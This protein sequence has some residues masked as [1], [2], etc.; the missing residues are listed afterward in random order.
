M[1]VENGK[2]TKATLDLLISTYEG[3]QKNNIHNTDLFAALVELKALREEYKELKYR[4][5]GLDK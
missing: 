2:V 1:T 3:Q 4:M 5:D